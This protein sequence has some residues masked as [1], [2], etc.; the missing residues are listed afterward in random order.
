MTLIILAAVFA[1]LGIALIHRVFYLLHAG[2][3]L[4]RTGR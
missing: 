1:V 2:K 4:C 3:Q